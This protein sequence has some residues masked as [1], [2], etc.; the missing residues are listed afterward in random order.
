MELNNSQSVSIT[1]SIAKI[2][3]EPDNNPYE[4]KDYQKK[5]LDNEKKIKELIRLEKGKITDEQRN[6]INTN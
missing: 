2:V 4:Y 3:F 1:E 6:L 5:E